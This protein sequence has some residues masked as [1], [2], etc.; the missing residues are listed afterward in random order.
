MLE[1]VRSQCFMRH[2][3]LKCVIFTGQLKKIAQNVSIAFGKMR[4]IGNLGTISFSR[5]VGAEGRG[6]E[7]R[8]GERNNPG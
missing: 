8:L 5:V 1:A 7:Q 2:G 4:L 6:E 3:I